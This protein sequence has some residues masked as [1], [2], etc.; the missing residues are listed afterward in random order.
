MNAFTLMELPQYQQTI[1][2]RNVT[3]LLMDVSGP[4]VH[5]M[6]GN[7]LGPNYPIPDPTPL[8]YWSNSRINFDPLA[9]FFFEYRR[10]VRLRLERVLEQSESYQDANFADRLMHEVRP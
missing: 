9:E 5:K 7:S 4:L 3:L 6:D 10:Y 8:T 1:E 2:R